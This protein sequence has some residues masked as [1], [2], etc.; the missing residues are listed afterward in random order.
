[1]YYLLK[2][3]RLGYVQFMMPIYIN[4]CI[5]V[6]LSQSTALNLSLQYKSSHT[7][8]SS[9]TTAMLR[10]NIF[11][12]PYTAHSFV[13]QIKESIRSQLALELV[14][15]SRHNS[16]K[17]LGKKPTLN[18]C[19]KP[20]TLAEQTQEALWLRHTWLS[21]HSP[22]LLHCSC[23]TVIYWRYRLASNY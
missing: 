19:T 3:E 8:I 15:D 2:D 5:S 14:S 17:V 10:K 21:H 23:L 16:E 1:M 11:T 9:I 12:S 20:R 6:W 4:S 7:E 22:V 13:K 18:P